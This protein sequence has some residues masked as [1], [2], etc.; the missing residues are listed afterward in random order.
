MNKGIRK[1]V[2]ALFL[3]IMPTAALAGTITIAALGDSLTAG[4]GLAQEEGF[5]P[6]LEAWLTGRGHDVKIINAGVSGDTTRGGLARADW[7][8]TPDV[9]A[10]IVALGGNDLL[11]GIDPAAS[12]ANLE[13]ILKKAK[14]K[15]LPVLLIGLKAPS[16]YGPDYKAAFDRIYPDL[17]TKYGAVLHDDFFR[18]LFNGLDRATALRRY[19]QA[20]GIH[21]NAKGVALL[22]AQ[23]GPSLEQV[24]N[25]ID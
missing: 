2:F 6:Q 14:A 7:T 20:D 16:N 17:A 15:S 21:P 3:L 18:G 22:V 5:V 19:M 11:R 1:A 23:I 12:R 9:D 10:L 4:Y 25:Q 13:G 24:I 8:L